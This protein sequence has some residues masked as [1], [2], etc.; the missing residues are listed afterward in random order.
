MGGSGGPGSRTRPL[1]FYLEAHGDTKELHPFPYRS[2]T[3]SSGQYASLATS[4]ED[5]PGGR[6]RC[7]YASG[8]Y[9]RCSERYHV[10]YHLS[11]ES[12]HL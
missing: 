9:W 11:N 7:V 2:L 4:K 10:T 1:I 8:R 6:C 5:R 12:R 3:H